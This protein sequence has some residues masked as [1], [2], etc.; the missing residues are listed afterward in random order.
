[1]ATTDTCILD[2]EGSQT[3]RIIRLGKN[4][5]KIAEVESPSKKLKRV[6]SLSN[7]ASRL[8]GRDPLYNFVSEALR[9][10]DL[11]CRQVDDSISPVS[12]LLRDEEALGLRPQLKV[13]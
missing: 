11:K 4:A 3:L 10:L 9:E 12:P 13:R 7:T 8:L 6:T 2:H 5:R 1:M